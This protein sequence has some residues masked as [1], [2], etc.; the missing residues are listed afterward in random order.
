MEKTMDFTWKAPDGEVLP[1]RAWGP[2]RPPRAT[3]VCL[4]GMGGSVGDF[5]PFGLRM[6]AEGYACAALTMR[7]Q[8]MDPNPRRRG[9]FFDAGVIGADFSA[10]SDEMREDFGAPD[11]VVCG[12]SLGALVAAR[13]LAT[14]G[15]PDARAAIFSAPV[16]GLT[17]ETPWIAHKAL[18][19]LAHFFPRGRLSPGWF[20]TGGPGSPKTSRDDEWNAAQQASPYRIRAFGF[21][22]LHRVG[23][24][25]GQMPEVAPAI[26]LPSLVLCAGRDVFVREEQVRQWFELLAADDKDL[27]V[28][29][30]AFHVLW[31]DL[32][33]ERVL[34]GIA[35]W[36]NNR[37]W[38]AD[39]RNT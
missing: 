30:E 32:D 12:E 25:I 16:V 20:V 2:S 5:D 27:H 18:E 19:C 29:P 22:V 39:V 13:Q 6:A 10:F 33:R 7:G 35:G 21:E 9:F 1:A 23:R 4:H 37:S 11:L 31:N 26:S 36:L 38:T 34:D 14:T 24:L 17:R 15:L 3:I 8:G 28:H